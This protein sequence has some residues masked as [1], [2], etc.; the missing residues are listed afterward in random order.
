MTAAGMGAES[1]GLSV[2]SR[3]DERMVALRMV[4]KRNWREFAW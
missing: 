1:A 3:T 2:R 4:E